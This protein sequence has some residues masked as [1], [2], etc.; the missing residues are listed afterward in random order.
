MMGL[1]KCISGFK[2]VAIFTISMLNFRG[3]SWKKTHVE[4]RIQILEN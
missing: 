3:V 2:N 1:G 4:T